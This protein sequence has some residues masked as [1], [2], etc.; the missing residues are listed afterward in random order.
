MILFFDKNIG[1]T[2]PQVLIRLKM[3]VQ[4][5]YHEKHFPYD[6]PDDKWLPVVG[7]NGWTVISHDRK[8]HLMPN[9]LVA[10]KQ[11][12]IGCFYLWGG[13]ATRWG[14]MQVFV[15]AYNRILKA[16]NHTPRPFIYDVDKRGKLKFVPIP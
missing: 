15:L 14:K 1:V 12:K 5:E 13:E 6:A 4:V 2:V 16:E 3:P 9:E 7:E 10:L 8:Y 11:Y